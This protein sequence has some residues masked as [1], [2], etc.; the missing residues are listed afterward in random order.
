MFVIL[1]ILAHMNHSISDH[2]GRR[3]A[4]IVI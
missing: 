4:P 2:G 1:F 3:F